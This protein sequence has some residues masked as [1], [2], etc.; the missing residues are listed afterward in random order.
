MTKQKQSHKPR[1]ALLVFRK[2]TEE[3]RILREMKL[4]E[5]SS[6]ARFLRTLVMEAVEQREVFSSRRT[7]S[8]P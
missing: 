4:A 7:D 1:S 6:F 5:E 8:A 3:K 2:P